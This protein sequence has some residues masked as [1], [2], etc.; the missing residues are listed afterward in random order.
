MPKLDSTFTRLT[1]NEKRELR[2]EIITEMDLLGAHDSDT[3]DRGLAYDLSVI[4]W[5]LS[6]DIALTPHLFDEWWTTK[7]ANLV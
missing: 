5:D 2:D 6:Y 1:H 7:Y 4:L 3:F